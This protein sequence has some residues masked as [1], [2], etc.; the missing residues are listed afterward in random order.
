MLSRLTGCHKLGLN[1]RSHLRSHVTMGKSGEANFK[2]LLILPDSQ[3]S[4]GKIIPESSVLHINCRELVKSSDYLIEENDCFTIFIENVE[5][6]YKSSYLDLNIAKIKMLANLKDLLESDRSVILSSGTHLMPY[7]LRKQVTVNPHYMI[8]CAYGL[9]NHAPKMD[10]SLNIEVLSDNQPYNE[11][12]D[13]SLCNNIFFYSGNNL[14]LFNDIYSKHDGKFYATNTDYHHILGFD[15]YLI[16]T[17][18]CDRFQLALY[19]FIYQKLAQNNESIL[20][21]INASWFDLKPINITEITDILGEIG[22]D[23][24]ESLVNIAMLAD[25]GIISIDKNG[26]IHST[27]PYNLYRYHS[28][29]E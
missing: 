25:M 18:D 5:Y 10:S 1:V 14:D 13:K 2:R 8:N 26:D 16:N 22:R 15:P 4:F 23:H 24:I 3:S 27:T 29:I 6:L 28:W 9:Y 17:S 21:S 20:N 11:S 12:L 7:M 19:K